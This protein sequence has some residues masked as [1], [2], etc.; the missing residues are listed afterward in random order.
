V[1]HQVVVGVPAT[2]VQELDGA[3]TD[4]DHGGGADELGGGR[5]LHLAPLVGAVPAVGDRAHEPGAPVRVEVRGHQLVTVDR[6]ADVGPWTEPGVAE[7]VVVV[8]V[9]VDDPPD[10]HG[11]ERG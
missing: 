2:E 3:V 11:S 7:A 1:Q 6:R 8:R 5:D 10:R 4:V 9:R